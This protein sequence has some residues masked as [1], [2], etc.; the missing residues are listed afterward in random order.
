MGEGNNGMQNF[1]KNFA[2]LAMKFY[3]GLCE[4]VKKY[5]F[6]VINKSKSRLTGEGEGATKKMWNKKKN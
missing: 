4:Q 2:K 5:L 1:L 6:Y 3:D